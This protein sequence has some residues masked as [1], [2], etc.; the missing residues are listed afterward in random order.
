MCLFKTAGANRLCCRF[1]KL[2]GMIGDE[3]CV[4]IDIRLIDRNASIYD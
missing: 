4:L 1:A 2:I 3:S